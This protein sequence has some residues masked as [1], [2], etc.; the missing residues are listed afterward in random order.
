M[1]RLL[2]TFE[3]TDPRTLE[4]IIYLAAFNYE[5]ALLSAG[6]VPGSDYS[7]RDLFEWSAPLALHMYE[8]QSDTSFCVGLPTDSLRHKT[9]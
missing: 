2:R 4:D 8:A 1:K 5:E 3:A 9:E 7:I 6:A